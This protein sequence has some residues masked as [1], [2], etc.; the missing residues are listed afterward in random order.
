M[1]YTEAMELENTHDSRKLEVI[2]WSLYTIVSLLA[3][4]IWGSRLSWDFSNLTGLTVFPLFGL[5]AFSLMWV[6]YVSGFVRD[7]W[8]PGASTKKSFSITTTIVLAL[9]L[10]HPTLLIVQLYKQGSGLPP[11]S[12]KDYVAAGNVGYV[13]LGTLGLAGLLT[14]EFKRFFSKKSWWKY[15]SVVSDIAILLIVV[16][17]LKLG[18]HLQTGWF[19]YLWYFYIITLVAAIIR[20][21]VLKF[22][23]S[24]NK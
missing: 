4:Y 24:K 8:F 6:H 10:L 21:Y 19:R 15:V 23:K 14:F 22:Q 7:T 17:S 18:Q 5:L 11:G 20:I 1:R 12:Y 13:L 3:I 9:I 16:H 2:L